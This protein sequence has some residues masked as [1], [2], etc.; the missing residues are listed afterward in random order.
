MLLRFIRAARQVVAIN[1]QNPQGG[2]NGRKRKSLLCCDVAARIRTFALG[3][4]L[5]PRALEDPVTIGYLLCRIAD[6][7]EDDRRLMP[8]RKLQLL[9]GLLQCFHDNGAAEDFATDAH[10]A[11]MSDSDRELIGGS[12]IVFRAFRALDPAARAILAEWVAEMTRGMQHFV[13]TYP[14]GIRI[15]SIA[16]FRRYCYFVAGTVGH[17]L[18]DLWYAHSPFI[19]SRTYSRLLVNCEAFARR[20]KSSISSRIFRGTSNTKT[21]FTFRATCSLQRAAATNRC[22]I[23]RCARGTGSHCRVSYR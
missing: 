2:G 3:I 4:R 10:G 23:R 1:R 17:L 14:A 7:I 5:L 15:E 18:T 11:G 6:T 9:E 20:C 16:E 8:E 13:R 12:S 22:S 21:R 19:R